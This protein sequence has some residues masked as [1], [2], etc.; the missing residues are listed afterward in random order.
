MDKDDSE[1]DDDEFKEF[2]ASGSEDE[3]EME[4]KDQDKIE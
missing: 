3:A 4:D 2:L 1:I